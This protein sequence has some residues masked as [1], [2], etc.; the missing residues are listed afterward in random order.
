MW[1]AVLRDALGGPLSRPAQ[2]AA[3]L[4][5]IAVF[6]GATAHAGGLFLP[7]HGARGL[8]RAGA[9]VAGADDPG[10]I[11]Y[12]PATI[13]RKSRL[14]L[15]VDATMVLYQMS[16]TR[17]D[18]GGNLLPNVR[19]EAVPLP[20]PTLAFTMP[21]EKRLWIGASLSAG[22]GV[23]PTYP[24]PS[25]GPCNPAAPGNCLDTAHFDAPQRYSLVSFEGTLFLRLDLAVAYQ[26]LPNL[27][28]GVA[29]QNSVAH[30][31]Q[32]KAITS[33]N[34]ALS[35]GPEDPDFDSL[36]EVKMT[37]LF[38]P[39]A[40]IGIVYRPFSNLTIA[41]TYQLPTWFDSEAQLAVQLP[42][43]PLYEASTVE[44]TSA[45]V[46]F[47]FPMS[48]A[49]GVEYRPLSRLR[50]ELDIVWENWSTLERIAFSPNDI[51]I[52]DLPG[53]GTYL[54]PSSYEYLSCQDSVSFRLGGE[55][56]FAA[57]PLVLR[58]GYGFELGATPIAATSVVSNDFN[59]HLFTVG[60][61]YQFGRVRVDAAYGF[62]LTP[63]RNVDFR[64][65]TAVQINP[66][67][68]TGVNSVGGGNYKQTHHSLGLGVTVSL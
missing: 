42:V 19:S 29:L 63:R 39:S 7:Y 17:V 56:H 55:Y 2:A 64:Q 10:G 20:I 38:N 50:V 4:L 59:K 3:A 13:D 41:L 65:S 1:W 36:T 8:G 28:I 24:R 58:M 54:V 26:L 14:E 43:S 12:N 27:T 32:V 18:S 40:Q 51:R 22:S 46:S 47:R 60:M 57:L 62:V 61:S 9:F 68:P 49:L 15:L 53:V 34:G 35:S 48:A 44:G 45:E 25:Y 21:V 37:D 11:W 31:S 16:Y 30:L 52:L 6:F 23:L 33:Y 5:L 67:N 66:V